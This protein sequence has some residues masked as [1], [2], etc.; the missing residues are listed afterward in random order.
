MNAW[1]AI[2]KR[3]AP[4][5]PLDTSLAVESFFR[6]GSRLVMAVCGVLLLVSV[7]LPWMTAS[8]KLG[9][10]YSSAS[11]MDISAIMG[12]TVLICGLVAAATAVLFS[13]SINKIV[14]II[15]GFIA[16]GAVVFVIA[17]SRLPL[18]SELG[19]ALI[20]VSAGFYL[21]VIA[22][23]ILLATGILVRR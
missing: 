2:I 20:V 15:I 17:T 12:V 16:L 6:S 14:Q 19:R 13:K 22:G 1:W 9:A 11:G 4:R 23:V 7:F 18:L 3:R 8:A 10:Q 5:Q 21:C